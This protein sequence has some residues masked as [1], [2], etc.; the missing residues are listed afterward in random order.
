MKS[1]L[2]RL[3][4]ATYNT[5]F[6]YNLRMVI[7]FSGTAFVP[8]FLGHQLMTIPLTLGVLAAGLSDIDDRFSVRIMNLVYTYIGFFITAASIQLLFPYPILFAIG[9]I[10][11]CIGW[12][13][14]GSLGRRYATISY[15]CLVVSVYSMLGVHLF[16]HW[17]TQPVLLVTGAAWYGLISTISFLLFPVR[18]VQDKLSQCYSSLGNFLYSKSNLFDVDMTASSYQKSM[19]NLTLENGQLISIFNDMKTALLTRLKGDRGLQD[20]RRSLQY[21]FVAQDIHERADSAHIDYQKL[22]KMFE[23]SDILFRF[24]RILSL[25]GKACK[26]LSDS[27]LH[28]STYQHN[29]RFEYAFE[30][31]RKSLDK[32][33]NDQYYDQIWVNALFAL[34]QNLKAIDAQLKNIETVRNIKLDKTK[35]IENQ[36][37]DDDLKGMQDIWIR[38]KQNL[39]PESVLFRHAIRVSVVLLIGYIFVQITNIQYGYW[40]LLTALFV[41]QPNFN[42]TKRRLR[43]RIIGTL[44]G[45]IAGYAI[46]YFVPSVEGQLVV[47]VLS[48][49]LFFELRS[50]Q[51]AQATAFIT[52][53]ALMNFNLDGLGFSAALP[54]MIDT[55]IGCALAWFGVSFIF[56]DW[57]FRR[58]PHSISR[59]LNAQCNYL[60]EVVSQYHHGK[61]NALNYRVVRRAAH[62]T[63]AEV[64]SLISTLA[65][66]PDIDPTQKS[67]AFEF[68]CLNHTFLS[69]IA[70]LGAHREKI[71]DPEI[72]KL[73]DQ[74]LDDIQGALLRDEVPDLTAHNML[75]SVR[76]RLN[77]S[78]H[79]SPKSLIILQQLSLMFS[80]LKSYSTLKQSLS[81][82]RD[83]DATELAS[84]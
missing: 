44:G 31:L 18:Q 82:D 16:E 61:N 22:A 11:S 76:Q 81:H 79:D 78:E 14:L 24:Q 64:A 41:S 20:T 2:T 10:I 62:N 6:M 80:I 9:L 33:R 45:I 68:L 1:W 19:I 46:L 55:V 67:L 5:T 37:K 51:Y 70:A 28:R 12:I 71:D 49:V 7:A 32:L 72:L 53:L 69:Y 36:L 34:Y 43:L 84:L 30:N 75:Q 25:Q 15:G 48:G 4:Q 83:N 38:I 3:K 59:S 13:L 47:L 74:A 39:T 63:D 73:L 58:L 17:Y 26:D 52:I 21:Y 27:I 23:H 40:V 56:P 65:T 29:S 42:A 54:R 77:Q 66:E 57:K 60:A 8:Y 50:K 35:Y